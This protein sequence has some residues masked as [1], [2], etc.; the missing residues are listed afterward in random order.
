[1]YSYKSSCEVLR[2]KW[3][4]SFIFIWSPCLVRKGK[5]CCLVRIML[6]QK[7]CNGSRSKYIPGLIFIFF[8]LQELKVLY[9]LW[10]CLFLVCGFLD[11]YH[12]SFWYA[13]CTLHTYENFEELFLILLLMYKPSGTANPWTPFR[14]DIVQGKF[15]A[16]I[17]SYTSNLEQPVRSSFRKYE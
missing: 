7:I 13:H 12:W 4:R 5:K 10:L 17:L 6:F 2:K 9:Y 16:L 3:L 1:M 14:R 11:L 8:Y 15:L